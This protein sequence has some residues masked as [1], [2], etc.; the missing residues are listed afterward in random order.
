AD[1]SPALPNLY[2]SGPLLQH[3]QSLFCYIYKFRARFGVIA[4]T[5]A[6]RLG[7]EW[8]EPLQQWQERGF[9]IEDLSCCEDCTCAVENE[10]K[11]APAEVEDFATVSR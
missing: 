6:D 7:V 11:E 10:E 8:E 1:E 5:I 3:R 9:L 2:Y 4:R